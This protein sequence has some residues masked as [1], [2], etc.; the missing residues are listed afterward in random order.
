[1]S[2]QSTKSR[3][4]PVRGKVSFQSTKS[5]G[6]PVGGKVSSQSTKSKREPVRGKVSL[7][8]QSQE[9]NLYQGQKNKGRAGRKGRGK[10]RVSEGE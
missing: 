5:R 9:G 2:S 4:D 7:R 1:M 3:R 10:K 8:V 6:E